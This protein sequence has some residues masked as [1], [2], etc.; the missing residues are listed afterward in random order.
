ATHVIYDEWNIGKIPCQWF[1]RLRT[2]VAYIVLCT[3]SVSVDHRRDSILSAEFK[4]WKHL[5]NSGFRR[6][7]L[8]LIARKF[9]NT[10]KT[11]VSETMLNFVCRCLLVRTGGKR[12]YEDPEL[13]KSNEALRRRGDNASN[14]VIRNQARSR[15]NDAHIDV[16]KVHACKQLF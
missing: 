10:A 4:N 16:M 7:R 11:E 1:K 9:G 2:N 6:L 12:G 8:P 3:S 14:L 5:A 15:I 13:C